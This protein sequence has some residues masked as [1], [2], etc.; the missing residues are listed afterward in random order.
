MA[1]RAKRDFTKG[2]YRLV[3]NEGRERDKKFDLVYTTSLDGDPNGWGLNVDLEIE[4]EIDPNEGLRK[5]IK[6]HHLTRAIWISHDDYIIPQ[7]FLKGNPHSIL[8]I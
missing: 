7:K 8:F 2:V 5:A 3:W 4:R 6:K 1:G